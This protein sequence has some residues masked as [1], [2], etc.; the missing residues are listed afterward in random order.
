MNVPWVL[1][2]YTQLVIFQRD[3][4]K[5]EISFENSDHSKQ[6]VLH[7]LARKLGL[8]YE[9][10]L[11]LRRVTISKTPWVESRNM[12]FFQQTEPSSFNST[13]ASWESGSRL[14]HSL[15][16]LTSPATS[17]S[18]DFQNFE[19]I[20]SPE[21]VPKTPQPKSTQRQHEFIFVTDPVGSPE[22]ESFR[23]RR[24]RLN[25]AARIESNAVKVVGAC[26]KCKYL[27]KKVTYQ[28][29]SRS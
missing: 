12:H 20:G 2:L 27:R 28:I 13:V 25:D 23:G 16:D 1:D 21:G 6:D 22:M 8:E 15:T 18:F 10:S 19:F 3:S 29:L 24:G 5:T 4:I 26:W 17:I 11:L 7:A 9:N 14:S